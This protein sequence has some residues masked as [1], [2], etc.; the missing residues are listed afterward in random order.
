M[1][2]YPDTKTIF[3][4]DTEPNT[5]LIEDKCYICGDN[6][7]DNSITLL[8]NHKF[9]STCMELNRKY[10]K[11][12]NCPYCRKKIDIVIPTTNQTLKC[13][14]I[15]KTGKNAGNSCGANCFNSTGYC[16]RHSKFIN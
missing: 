1:D 13:G 14:A 2:Y 9:H 15:L 8:C 10:S 6:N 12:P 3:T 7:D 4:I 11:I 16:K 5:E